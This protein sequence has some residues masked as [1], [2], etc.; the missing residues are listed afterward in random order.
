MVTSQ[1]GKKAESRSY[2]QRNY[3]ISYILNATAAAAAIE[4]DDFGCKIVWREKV[5]RN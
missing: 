1:V 3:S 2:I 5:D 4:R